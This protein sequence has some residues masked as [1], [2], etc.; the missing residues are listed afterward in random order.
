MFAK[1]YASCV[2][3]FIRLVSKPDG[4][5]STYFIH[6]SSQRQIHP[7]CWL[8]QWVSV[9][10]HTGGRPLFWFTCDLE[11]R[12]EKTLL[13]YLAP[14]N[15]HLG[16]WWLE[17]IMWSLCWFMLV[18]STDSSLRT[19]QCH[20]E[21]NCVFHPPNILFFFLSAFPIRLNCNYEHL[22]SGNSLWIWFHM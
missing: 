20:T 3:V 8:A 19:Y 2:P 4:C 11:W 9:A 10:L 1:N 17:T 18:T 6:H 15:V 16:L 21:N 22:S 5:S 7:L 12:Q 14:Y 13:K